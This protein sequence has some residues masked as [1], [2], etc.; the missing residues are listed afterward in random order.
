MA[1]RAG[2]PIINI[3]FLSSRLLSP[4]GNYCPNYGDPRN[5]VQ[6][7]ARITGD[8]GDIIVPRTQFY[9]WENLGKEKIDPVEMRG[10]W[11]EDRKMW[12]GG[13]GSLPKRVNQGEGPFYLD[14]SEATEEEIDY[15]AWSIRNEGK[16]TQFMRYFE[17]EEGLDLRKNSQEYAGWAN[18]ELAGTAAKGLWVDRDLETEIRNLFAAGDEVGGVP[19]AASPG[20]FTMGWHAGEMAAKRA[21]ETKQF[22]PVSEEMV[23]IRKSICSEILNRGRGFY[24]KEVELYVQNLMDFYCGDVRGEGL[25]KRGLE[26]L[27]Y[28][29]K[30]PLKAENPHELSRALEVKSIVDNAELVLRSSIE[31]RESRPS[32]DFRRI[33]YPEQ[34]DKN[35]FVF[36]AI[37]KEEVEKYTFAKIP[38]Q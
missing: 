36:L 37:R 11:L 30:A 7:A 12:R 22:L 13:R 6:P 34:D 2:L 26:R 16:G 20:A 19:W 18:R 1:I 9:N 3:E 4:C 25:L 33:D 17:E 24:W 38:I 10:R 35:W 15:I 32:L 21:M 14:F 28:A 29:R 8:I 5:T 31:R 27:E 23:K